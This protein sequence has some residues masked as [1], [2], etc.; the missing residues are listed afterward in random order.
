VDRA[1]V[2]AFVTRARAECPDVELETAEL[3][4][5]L[6]RV[7]P[8]GD[9]LAKLHAGDLLLAAAC[10]A[11]VAGAVELLERRHASDLRA[12]IATIDPAPAFADEIMQQLLDK[13][14]VASGDDVPK[15]A[16]YA[17]TGPLG[18]WLRVAA[19]RAAVSARRRGWREVPGDDGLDAVAH[20]ART[21]EQLLAHREHGEVFRTA[22]RE[23]IAAQPSRTRALLRYYYSD[24]VGVEELGKIYRVHAST[25]SRWLAQARD[26]ILVETRRRLAT[27]LR[28]KETDIE[29]LLGLSGS[30]DVSLN[31]LLRSQ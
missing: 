1:E 11:R 13:L 23:A 25:A 12:A 14:L 9:A 2:D 17:G 20:A 29:S 8:T 26:A 18:G 4:A 15:L 19:L 27:A 28:Q 31:T 16:S 22:L 10:L 7:C 5:H 3:V 24:G 6:E 30:L 21:P